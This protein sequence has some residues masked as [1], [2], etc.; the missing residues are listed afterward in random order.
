MCDRVAAHGGLMEQMVPN[1]WFRG[2]WSLYIY[3]RFNDQFPLNVAY[4]LPIVGRGFF[5]LP[6]PETDGVN[7]QDIRM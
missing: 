3:N 5:R 6:P 7:H 4:L 1:G 2:C